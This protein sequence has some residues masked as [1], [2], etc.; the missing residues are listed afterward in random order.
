MKIPFA[1]V[2][3][4]FAT[5]YQIITKY[6]VYKSRGQNGWALDR[7]LNENGLQV[8]LLNQELLPEW[9]EIKDVENPKNKK[10]I[11]DIYNQK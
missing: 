4:G 7:L 5:D 10:K 1:C 6:N 9:F 2:H 8:E 11:I 3:R